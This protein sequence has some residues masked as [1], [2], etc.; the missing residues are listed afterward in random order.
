MSK[1]IIS[2]ENPWKNLKNPNEYIAECDKLCISCLKNSCRGD[3]ELKLKAMPGPYTG[4]PEKSVVY[5]L[6]LNPGYT[7]GEDEKVGKKHR[8]IFAKNLLHLVR[9]C[10]FISFDPI[11]EGSKG[12][13]WW[14]RMLGPIIDEVGIKAVSKYVFNAEYFPYHSR[15]FKLLK[16]ILPSQNYT[17]ELVKKAI[18]DKKIIIIMRSAKLWYGAIPELE[19]YKNTY[20]L[21]NPRNVRIT[22][23]NIGGE[24]NFKKIVAR[25][26]KAAKK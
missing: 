8:D 20:I 14:K 25:I 9:K 6:A 1:G 16:K 3:Y 18:R 2:M 17:F 5:V 23:N 13:L 12:Q 21:R 4:D 15:R 24:G 7:A 11:F 19:K 10:P 22:P 26:Q